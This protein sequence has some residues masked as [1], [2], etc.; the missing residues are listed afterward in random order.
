[1]LYL[2]DNPASLRVMLDN[3]GYIERED[4]SRYY[5]RIKA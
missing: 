3:G 1:M 2:K 4:E 5:V